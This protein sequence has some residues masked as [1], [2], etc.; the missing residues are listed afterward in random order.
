ML[1]TNEQLE[2]IFDDIPDD[3]YDGFLSYGRAIEAAVR[4]EQAGEIARLREA[5]AELL[6]GLR[7]VLNTRCEEARAAMA[8]TNAQENYSSYDAEDTAHTKAMVAASKAERYAR[9]LIA[10]HGGK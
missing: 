9:E 5:N 3:K 10:K 1:L 8:L 4:E 6:E 2:Q 7:R